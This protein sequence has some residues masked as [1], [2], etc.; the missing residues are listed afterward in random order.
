MRRRAIEFDH[1]A[2]TFLADQGDMRDSHDMAA[3]HPYEQARIELRL[4]FRDRPRAHPLAGA[5]M[6]PGIMGVS[7]HAPHIRAVDEMSAVRA[8]DRKPGGRRGAGRLTEAAEWRRHQ[9]R[10]VTRKR[11]SI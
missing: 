7:P 10:E 3:V 6:N 9:P 1:R 4:G 8:L 5:V 11:A 2:V